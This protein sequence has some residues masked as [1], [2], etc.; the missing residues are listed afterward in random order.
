MTPA[1]VWGGTFQQYTPEYKD[2]LL[3][4]LRDALISLQI[5]AAQ[6]DN[7]K[8][9]DALIPLLKLVAKTPYYDQLYFQNPELFAWM[10]DLL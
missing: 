6:E 1:S 7:T 3:V 5:N 9:H 10:K 8:L 2:E 4:S